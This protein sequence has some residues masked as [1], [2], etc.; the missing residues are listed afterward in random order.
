MCPGAKG[1]T[2]MVAQGTDIGPCVARDPEQDEPFLDTK[3]SKG[4]DG[5]DPQVPCNGTSPWGPL[6]NSPG[7]FLHYFIQPL[8]CSIPVESHKADI[9]FP[10]LE[11]EG[12][13]PDCPAE[14]DQQDSGNLRVK[15]PGVTHTDP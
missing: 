7:E 14:H 13:E 8:P 2:D 6:V 15:G 11:K 1:E 9:F 10:V 4:V 3:D 5:A 12:C